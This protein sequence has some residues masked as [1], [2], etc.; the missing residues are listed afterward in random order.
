MV[1]ARLESYWFL[2]LGLV[3]LVIGDA[4]WLQRSRLGYYLAAVREDED[5]ARSL[6]VQVVRSKLVASTASAALAALAGTFYAQFIQYIDPD[7]TTEFELS[8]QIALIAIV[9]GMGTA[10]GPLIGAVIIIPLG[11]ILRVQF[12]G[13]PALMVY[14]ALLTIIVLAWPSGVLGGL[15]SLGRRLKLLTNGG[16]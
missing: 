11:E 2:G 9:G 1:F 10:F 14:G 12:G 15:K 4:I 16:D 6:G 3:A 8:V 5:A 13:G 7:S